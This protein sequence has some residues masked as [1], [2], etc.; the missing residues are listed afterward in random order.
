VTV[1]HDLIVVG[2]G[3]AGLAAG[4]TARA[5]RLRAVVLDAGPEPGG[6]LLGNPTPILDCPGIEANTGPELARKLQQHLERLGGEVRRAAVQRLDVVAGAVELAGERLNASTLLLA[7]GASRRRLGVRGERDEPG[8][9]LSPAARLFGPRF[10]GRPVVVVGGGDV[11][12]E[13]AALFARLCPRVLLVHHGARLRG[14]PDFRAAV[15]AD[16][17]IDVHLETRLTAIVGDAEVE[18][19][20]VVGPAG[21]RRV[22]AAAVVVCAGLAPR[23]ELVSGQVELDEAGFVRVDLRQRTSAARLYAAGDVCAGSSW[24]V[25]SAMGQAAAAVKDIERRL[26]S[27]E[28]PMVSSPGSPFAP[29]HWGPSDPA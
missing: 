10:A 26:A 25:V 27:G 16:P 12:L 8:R 29:A 18:G 14:R 1:E 15:A 7:S 11:A 22:E 13:E 28:F 17:R 23:S 21:E 6:Q 4:I 20:V 24:T 2:A 19:A 3:P 5:L 9:G